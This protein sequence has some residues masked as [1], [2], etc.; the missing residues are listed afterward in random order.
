M[1]KS[2]VLPEIKVVL[3]PCEPGERAIPFDYPDNLG[4]RT[5]L[6]G[7]P[8]WIQNEAVPRCLS[9]RKPMTF[10]AQI[11]SIGYESRKN[12]LSKEVVK[13]KQEYMFADVGMIY[14]FFCFP[15]IETQSVLQYY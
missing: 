5:K 15:C 9:C 7:K 6:G 12:P 3:S 1:S 11:D 8:D 2:K 14:V 4:L 10:V 13:E